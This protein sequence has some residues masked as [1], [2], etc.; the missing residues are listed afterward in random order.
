MVFADLAALAHVIIEI[1][2]KYVAIAEAVVVVAEVVIQQV[3][4]TTTNNSNN[5][6]DPT[7]VPV[8]T[9][10]VAIDKQVDTIVINNRLLVE[11]VI[12]K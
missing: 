9:C 4:T 5:G 1:Q 11:V 8:E 7:V 6:T 2:H 3:D 10:A 12:A